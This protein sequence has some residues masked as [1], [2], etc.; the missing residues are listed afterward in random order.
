MGITY[1][2]SFTLRIIAN[3]FLFH[4]IY[5]FRSEGPPHNIIWGTRLLPKLGGGG[6]QVHT[7]LLISLGF[8]PKN[9][10]GGGPPVAVPL[11]ISLHVFEFFNYS[12]YRCF[13]LCTCR[14][15]CTYCTCVSITGYWLYHEESSRRV[16]LFRAF[17]IIFILFWNLFFR[18]VLQVANYMIITALHRSNNLILKII[19]YI[20]IFFIN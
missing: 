10:W 11:S 17:I 19:E 4:L 1:N 15:S 13:Y 2:L 7:S 14:S 8:F 16:F 3:S 6:G 18:S 12:S 20:P 9:V 5:Y